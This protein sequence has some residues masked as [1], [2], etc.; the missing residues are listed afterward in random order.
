[1]AFLQKMQILLKDVKLVALYLLVHL[2]DVIRQMGDKITAKGL[3][4]E[5]NI[6][7]VPGYKGRYLKLMKK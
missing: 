5:S 1:M 7:I 2:Q 6:P 4:E 3:A